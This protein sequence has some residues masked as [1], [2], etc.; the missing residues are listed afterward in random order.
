MIEAQQECNESRH[1]RAAVVT[2]QEVRWEGVT[3]A[4]VKVRQLR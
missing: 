3:A 1:S 2:A 4:M